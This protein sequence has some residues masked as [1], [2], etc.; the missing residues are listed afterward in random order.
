MRQITTYEGLSDFEISEVYNH[1]DLLGF[2]LIDRNCIEN[3]FAVFQS[4]NNEIR[5]VTQN[6]SQDFDNPVDQAKFLEL[7]RDM[8]LISQEDLKS[9]L[10]DRKTEFDLVD[11]LYSEGYPEEIIYSS[12]KHYPVIHNALKFT[13]TPSNTENNE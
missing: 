11:R 8:G 6:I 4:V 13:Q 10:E 2:H 1:I 12:F 9:K 5:L 3:A 7:Q